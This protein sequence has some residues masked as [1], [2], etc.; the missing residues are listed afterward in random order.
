MKED[1]NF[2]KNSQVQ[3]CLHCKI[4]EYYNHNLKGKVMVKINN[5]NEDEWG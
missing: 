1:N 3:K 4:E 5:I 2:V